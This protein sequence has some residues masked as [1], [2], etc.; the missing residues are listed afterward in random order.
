MA[1]VLVIGDTHCPAMRPDYIP[2]LKSVKRKYKCN[3]VVHIG[4]LVDWAAIS[5]HPKAPSLKNSELEFEMAYQQVQQ[6]RKAFPVATWLLGNHGTLTERHANDLGLPLT[7]LK[8]YADLWGLPNWEVVPRYSQCV[9]DNVIFQHGDRGKGGQ[10][11]AAYRNA[12]DERMPVV[13]GHHHSQA[14]VQYSAN[15]RSTIWGLQVGCGVDGE[16]HAMDYGKKYNQK[17]INGC[18]IVLNRVPHFIPMLAR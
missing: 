17:P 3:K 18:G 7:V 8:D 10:G 16:S 13:Q 15:G 4:D 14:G 2:F 6:L 11:N 1:N 5:Y 9:I 12:I